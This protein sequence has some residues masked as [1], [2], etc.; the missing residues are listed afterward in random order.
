MFIKKAPQNQQKLF[1]RM[2]LKQL[3]QY[4]HQRKLKLSKKVPQPRSHPGKYFKCV[5]IIYIYLV[6]LKPKSFFFYI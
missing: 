6:Y 3:Q 2:K 4:R 5:N 1:Q